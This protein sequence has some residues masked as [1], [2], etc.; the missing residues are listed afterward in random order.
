MATTQLITNKFA[1]FSTEAK[2]DAAVTAGYLTSNTIAF[3]KEEGNEFIWTHGTK[4]K[5]DLGR[6]DVQDAVTAIGNAAAGL[7]VNSTAIRNLLSTLQFGG[8]NGDADQAIVQVTQSNGI[9]T[10]TKG[11]IA[12]EHVTYTHQQT[13]AQGVSPV[14]YDTTATNV[15][16]AIAEIYE[17]VSDTAE[18]SVVEVYQ[19]NTKLGPNDSISAGTEYTIKQGGSAVC[20]IDIAADMVVKN[21]TVITADGTEKLGTAQNAASAGLTSGKTY[22]KLEIANEDTSRNLLYIDAEK[23]VKDHTGD[24]TTTITVSISD[25]RV[26]TADVNNNSIG[27]GHLTTGSSE[28]QNKILAQRTTITPIAQTSP[29]TK[30]IT[31]T[32]TAG[33][34]ANGTGDNYVIAESDIASASYVGTIPGTATATDVVGY[35]DEKVAAIGGENLWEPGTATGSLKTK[36]NQSATSAITGERSIAAGDHTSTTNAAEAAFGVY[37]TSITGETD[38]SKTMFSVGIGTSTATKNGFDVRKN[39]NLY[40]QYGNPTLGTNATYTY[41]NLTQKFYDEFEWYEDLTN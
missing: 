39:G 31:V 37:N 35:V 12:A 34:D 27:W 36:S 16:D 26:I 15:Q 14:T 4:F 7:P 6:E 23:L 5:C 9:V 33:N 2:L 29:A 11:D 24:D 1:I 20:K 22:I 17:K 30:H 3:C 19:G 21:G 8:A 10:A 25:S 38:G 40:G 18:D 41:T 13:S 28:L 32:K